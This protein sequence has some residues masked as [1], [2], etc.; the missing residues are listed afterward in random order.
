MEQ[1]QQA[2]WQALQGFGILAVLGAAF[3]Q[4]AIFFIMVSV[5]LVAIYLLNVFLLGVSAGDWGESKSEAYRWNIDA[6]SSS[7][8]WHAK[9]Y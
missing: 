4:Y 8:H 1:D 9:C 3:P 6:V 5:I 2:G 7:D